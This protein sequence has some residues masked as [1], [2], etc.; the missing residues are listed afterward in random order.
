MGVADAKLSH[1][2]KFYAFFE[3]FR[4][5]IAL[6]DKALLDDGIILLHPSESDLIGIF[7][8]A[9]AYYYMYDN[10]SVI[11]SKSL[12]SS[13]CERL[14]AYPP[15][16]KKRIDILRECFGLALLSFEKGSEKKLLEFL[17]YLGH[18]VGT[19]KYFSLLVDFFAKD[20]PRK[21]AVHFKKYFQ[22]CL[23]RLAGFERPAMAFYLKALA[24]IWCVEDKNFGEL[25][26]IINEISLPAEDA[27]FFWS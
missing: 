7:Y 6:R 16:S 10:V 14:A 4:S 22:Q 12:L 13:F 9:L 25:R 17:N 3:E 11:V 8:L 1:D 23:D 20:H 26:V 18:K 19:A 21:G 15:I 27:F 24:L 5:K 2:E